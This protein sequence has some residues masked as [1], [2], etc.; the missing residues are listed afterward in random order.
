[1][2]TKRMRFVSSWWRQGSS[3]GEAADANREKFVEV[4]ATPRAATGGVMAGVGEEKLGKSRPITKC[5][6]MRVTPDTSRQ[7]P[8]KDWVCLLSASDSKSSG[9]SGRIT[10]RF[11]DLKG[12]CVSR[13]LIQRPVHL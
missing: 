2:P 11:A 7:K 3:A 1:M 9:L 6:H 12:K 5:E 8:A 13:F 4:A 10:A